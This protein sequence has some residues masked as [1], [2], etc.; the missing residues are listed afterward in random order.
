[1]FR[2]LIPLLADKF[3]IVAPDLPGFGQSDMPPREKF[4]YT[5]DNIAARDR[6][7]H[8]GHRLRSLCGVRLR[9]R[10]ADRLPARRPPPRA[11]HRHH[12]AERQRLRGRSQRRLELR[13]RPTG[14]IRRRRTE[15][16]SAPSSLRRRP[17]GSTRTA[18]RTRRWCR[19]MVRTS[20]TFIWPVP[21]QMTCSSTSSATTRATS[22][23][24]R[25]SRNISART[26]R[27]CWRRGARTIRSS[28]RPAPRRSSGT[29]PRAVVRFFDTGHF[30]LET[31]A[32]EIAESIRD[33]L[34]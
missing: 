33:F 2:D 21:V 14:R 8:R 12:L 31:H 24:I 26:S 30:A 16:R 5:F 29:I 22:R 32:R 23:C 9:L 1:M 4:S 25:H 6:P 3:H 20:T 13:S 10:R 27:R 11:D 18:C 28:C 15:R 34:K 7:L 19:R 17:A